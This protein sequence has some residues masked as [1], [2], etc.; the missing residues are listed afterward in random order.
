MLRRQ[1]VT[2]IYVN[3]PYLIPSIYYM[4]IKSYRDPKSCYNDI[5]KVTIRAS[6][7]QYVYMSSEVV[8]RLSD[9][10]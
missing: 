7:W 10:N 2:K 5:K 9:E 3:I 6:L 8:L 4:L 1:Q